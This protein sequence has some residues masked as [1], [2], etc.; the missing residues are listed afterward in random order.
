MYFLLTCHQVYFRYIP[1]AG[2]DSG[3]IYQLQL[4]D[5]INPHATGYTYR[6]LLW[7]GHWVHLQPTTFTVGQCNICSVSDKRCKGMHVLGSVLC[8]CQKNRVSK[9]AAK[10]NVPIWLRALI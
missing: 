10:G 5:L 9:G 6:G 3:L 7:L 4:Q 1:V 2:S 8:K